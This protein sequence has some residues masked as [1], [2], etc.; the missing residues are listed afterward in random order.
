MISLAPSY[1][2]S[3]NCVLCTPYASSVLT[4]NTSSC[5][6]TEA[7]PVMAKIGCTIRLSPK[8]R[9][10]VRKPTKR[11]PEFCCSKIHAPFIHRAAQATCSGPS[12]LYTPP[13]SVDTRPGRRTTP[14]D[15]PATRNWTS[16]GAQA[17]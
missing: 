12:A 15:P 17:S 8:P 2:T 16:T 7:D 3:H 10:G 6:V 13:S 14:L 4:S 5:F 9:P 11:H 1:L